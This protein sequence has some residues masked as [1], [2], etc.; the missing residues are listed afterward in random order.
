MIK[1]TKNWKEVLAAARFTA[2]KC[3]T[4]KE[5]SV[6]WKTKML[7]AEHSPIRLLRIT[8][9]FEQI[10]TWVSVHLVRHHV[11]IE[12][13][14]CSQRSDRTG[15]SRDNKP[16][17][18]PV[19]HMI[20]ANAQAVINMARKRLCSLASKET[21][22]AFTSLVLE[23]EKE[24]PELARVCVPDCIYRGHCFEPNSCGWHKSEQFAEKRALY[25]RVFEEACK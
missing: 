2:G 14:V 3:D 20:N 15:I 16:Q 25:V 17:S 10:K 13:F 8:G 21:R 19:N 6:K 4:K 22:D 24:E 18:S 1:S 11:G 12:H 23:I 9:V 5:P 7:Y